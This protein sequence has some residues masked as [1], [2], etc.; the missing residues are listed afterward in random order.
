MELRTKKNREIR[1]K[2]NQLHIYLLSNLETAKYGAY[3]S[4]DS[5]VVV[6][7][8]ED[9]ARQ[10]VPDTLDMWVTPD[11]VKVELVGIASDG[12]LEGEVI[13]S[14]YNAG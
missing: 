3:D 9:M 12:Q 4:Y 1:T 5:C 14:S 8:S 6:S 2:K 13:C 7:A 10:I 11:Q